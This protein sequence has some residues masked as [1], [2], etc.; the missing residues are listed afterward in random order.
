[1]AAAP[2]PVGPRLGPGCARRR[3]VSHPFLRCPAPF[4]SRSG[5]GPPRLGGRGLARAGFGLAGLGGAS[6]SPLPSTSR[7]ARWL[8]HLSMC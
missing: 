2:T 4:E 6:P 3:A 5:G 1:M 8:L 7:E